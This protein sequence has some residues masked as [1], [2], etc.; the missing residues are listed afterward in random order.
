MDV[1]VAVVKNGIFL[2]FHTLAMRSASNP[3]DRLTHTGEAFR[4]DMKYDKKK[5]RDDV[6]WHG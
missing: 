5:S 2:S 1:P 6:G 4:G 3:I